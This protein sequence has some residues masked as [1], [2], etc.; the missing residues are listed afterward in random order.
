MQVQGKEGAVFSPGL[1]VCRISPQ[2]TQFSPRRRSRQGSGTILEPTNPQ[3]DTAR[4]SLHSTTTPHAI[5]RKPTHF[6]SYSWIVQNILPLFT[7][8]HNIFK[9]PYLVTQ[10]PSNLTQPIYVCFRVPH[11]WP[12]QYMN[13][14]GSISQLHRLS[15]TL[16]SSPYRILAPGASQVN[17]FKHRWIS[18]VSFIAFVCKI[19]NV[20]WDTFDQNQI[21]NSAHHKSFLNAIASPSRYTCRSANGS[22]D[23]D[24]WFVIRIYCQSC[25][26]Y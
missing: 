5:V 10:G 15:S 14:S 2:K 16:F 8:P 13:V 4:S 9:G 12:G 11:T 6:Q 18:S 7:N 1:P 23:N 19:W 26:P 3:G 17:S 25:Q 21:E 24:F 22:V 20:L